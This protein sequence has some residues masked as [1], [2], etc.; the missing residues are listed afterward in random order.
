MCVMYYSIMCP[1]PLPSPVLRPSFNILI[2]SALPWVTLS[3]ILFYCNLFYCI[4]LY[5]ILFIIFYSILF[6][7]IIFYS[8]L[9]YSILFYSILFYSILLYILF[10]S[11][12]SYFLNSN[13]LKFNTVQCKIYL[14]QSDP[15]RMQFYAK[16][17]EK[18][19]EP[20]LTYLGKLLYKENVV[21]IIKYTRPRPEK[22]LTATA[23]VATVL[24]SILAPSDTVES[25][26]RQMKQC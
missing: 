21:I 4:V 23:K 3:D 13:L 6:Y 24:G 11:I 18:F 22:G 10:Y 1:E 25:V 12:L 7:S 19:L 2:I 8:I 20:Y 17:L 15:Q 5:C 14:L 16:L 26:G 9:F